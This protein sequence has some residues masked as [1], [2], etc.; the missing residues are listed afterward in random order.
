MS[1]ERM[2]I[3]LIILV[4]FVKSQVM[5]FVEFNDGGDWDI[6]YYIDD[7]VLVDWS[8]AGQTKVNFLSGANVRGGVDAYGDSEVS[9][10]GG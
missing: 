4:C 10:S 6:Q 1:Y 3:W 5:A 2:T 7:S 8:G 9:V